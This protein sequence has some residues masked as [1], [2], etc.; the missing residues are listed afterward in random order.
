MS[1]IRKVND[2]EKVK[3]DNKTIEDL[4]NSN[5]AANPKAVNFVNAN[6]NSQF[7]FPNLKVA[8]FVKCV[9]STEDETEIA[10][11]RKAAL[12]SGVIREHKV[13]KTEAPQAT[14]LAK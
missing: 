5:V 3:I 6:E 7:V 14:A 1:A 4:L 9:Y 10:E 11:L 8:T 12:S 2:K 13:E